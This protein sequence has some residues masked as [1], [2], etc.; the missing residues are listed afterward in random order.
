[1][2]ELNEMK[3]RENN[4]NEKINNLNNENIELELKDTY[5]IGNKRNQ[6][7]KKLKEE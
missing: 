6:E 5:D 7:L 2:T 1:M 3:F 4:N